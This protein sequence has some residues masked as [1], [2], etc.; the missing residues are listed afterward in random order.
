MSK[1][2]PLARSAALAAWGFVLPLLVAAGLAAGWP[3]LRTLWFGFTDAILFDGGPAH[4]VGLDNYRLLL[5]DPLW[6][7]AVGNTL[8]FTGASVA[9]EMILGLGLALLLDAP[10]RGRW[11]VRAA[12][13]VPWAVPTVV[14]AKMWGWMLHDQYGVVNDAL[15][16][17]GLLSQ[18]VAWTADPA[19]A[20]GSVIAVDVWKTTPF[21]ALILLAGL[22]AVPRE[23]L[24]AARVDGAGPLRRFFHITLPLL[25]PALLVALVFRTLD[26][27]R[28]FDVIYVLTG[29]APETLSMSGYARMQLIAFQDVGLGSAAASF[30]FVAVAITAM[31]A[32]LLLGRYRL[33]GG[34][35]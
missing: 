35:A 30:L 18:P 23:L 9:L 19:L 27:L 3:L 5:E 32:A 4:L 13:M 22:Q 28:V 17:L 31:V 7:E 8:A 29:D 15:I 11:L 6:Q 21:V 2:R 20:L 24:E 1:S 25:I 10:F 33:R 16:R 26:A 34:M 14:A 12:V